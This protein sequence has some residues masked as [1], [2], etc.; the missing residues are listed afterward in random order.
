MI[1]KRILFMTAI[2]GAN[3]HEWG[4]V[5]DRIIKGGDTAYL[6]NFIMPNEKHGGQQMLTIIRPDEIEL[7][8][9]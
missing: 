8:E 2:D 7:I 9:Q 1:G 3:I 4:T 6:V 5:E